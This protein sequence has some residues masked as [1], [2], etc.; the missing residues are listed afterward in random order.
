[1][2]LKLSSIQRLAKAHGIQLSYLAA[3]GEERTAPPETLVNLLEI[4]GL[5]R[6]NEQEAAK[7]LRE[8]KARAAS[9]PLGP[10]HVLWDGRS[11]GLKIPLPT[12]SARLSLILENG[13]KQ[14][15]PPPA[16]AALGLDGQAR[17]SLPRLP[18]GYHTLLLESGTDRHEALLISAPTRVYQDPSGEREWGFFAPLYAVHDQES[19]GAGSFT[20]W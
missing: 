6:V 8:H 3:T 4:L 10:V 12:K 7:L 5:G 9:Q 13:E 1:M 15:L 14:T 11:P 16:Q 17:L 2:P 19:W 20:D 18:I